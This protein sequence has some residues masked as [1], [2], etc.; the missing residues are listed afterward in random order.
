M[1]NARNSIAPSWL[2]CPLGWNHAEFNPNCVVEQYTFR[3][4]YLPGAE[5]WVPGDRGA[6]WGLVPAGVRT[7]LGAPFYL[8]S[9]QNK[10]GLL[11]YAEPHRSHS[12]ANTDGLASGAAEKLDSTKRPQ[13]WPMIPRNATGSVCTPRA[14]V[15][16]NWRRRI[17]LCG[18]N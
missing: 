15:L 3:L 9:V 13:P 7:D 17:Q 6:C 16:R 11:K 14:P 5:P 8:S 2:T 10:S 18:G 1:P 4:F 12:R